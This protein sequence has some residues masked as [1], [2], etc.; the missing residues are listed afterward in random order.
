MERQ[1]KLARKMKKITLTAAAKELGVSQPTLSGWEGGRKN[2]SIDS[3]IRMSEYYGV[4]VDFLL[5]LEQERDPRRDLMQ[6]ISLRSLPA[7]HET[8]VF[9]PLHGWAF[10]DVAEQQL[11]FAGGLVLPF[12]DAPELYILPPSFSAAAA[13][14]EKPLDKGELRGHD[15]VWVEP[16]SPDASLRSELRGWYRVKA[17]HVE[18]EVGQRFYFDFYGAKWLAFASADEEDE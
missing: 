4:S 2:P 11:R 18:N 16:I 8:P 10:V 9:S 14:Q 15:E 17:R 1:Y 7:L 12:A 6:P 3:L 5:G 13:P